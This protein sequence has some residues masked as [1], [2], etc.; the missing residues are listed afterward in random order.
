MLP[1]LA[2]LKFKVTKVKYVSRD[3]VKQFIKD[4]QCLRVLSGQF[5]GH[6]HWDMFPVSTP[7]A[8]RVECQSYGQ[9]QYTRS[10][11]V[12]NVEISIA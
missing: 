2:I 1:H 6:S 4:P 12:I 5:K 10:Q 8:S 3:K 11:H 9:T 7:D